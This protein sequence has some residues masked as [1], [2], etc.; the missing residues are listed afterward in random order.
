MGVARYG[1]LASLALPPLV[2]LGWWLGGG[3]VFLLPLVIWVVL[4]V[5]DWLVGADTR[6]PSPETVAALDADPFYRR[7][8]WLQ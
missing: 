3:W 1:F 5:V 7:V 2:V 8:L 4:P 6:N